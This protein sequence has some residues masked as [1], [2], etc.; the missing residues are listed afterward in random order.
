MAK[1][2]PLKVKVGDLLLCHEWS[3][4]GHRDFL[5]E[6][7]A[8]TKTTATDERGRAWSL[9]TMRERGSGPSTWGGTHIVRVAT[10]E[11][12]QR[13]MEERR[14]ENL[15]NRIRVG[16]ES[17]LVKRLEKVPERELTALLSAI[18]SALKAAGVK[19]DA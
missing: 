2:E 13:V 15:R 19:T 1:R 14:L 5:I 12:I 4:R 9:V 18:E 17:D 8:A 3:S 6:S 10:R 11:D 16:Y 7:K